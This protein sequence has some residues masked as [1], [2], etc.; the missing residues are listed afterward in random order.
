MAGCG[1]W[2]LIAWALYCYV[3]TQRVSREL[4]T[5]CYLRIDKHGKHGQHGKGEVN[6]LISLRRRKLQQFH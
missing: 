6:E 2:Q 5:N 3:K 4:I 1:A